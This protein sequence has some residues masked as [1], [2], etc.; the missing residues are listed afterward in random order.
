[1]ANDW[2]TSNWVAD[3]VN[4][5]ELRLR[6]ELGAM[7]KDMENQ[8]KDFSS[9]FIQLFDDHEEF[10]V[11]FNDRLEDLGRN[12]ELIQ[13]ELKSTHR[14]EG[15]SAHERQI[16]KLRQSFDV[17]R[18]DLVRL[19]A[20]IPGEIA[21]LQRPILR[22]IEQIQKDLT[23]FH[24]SINFI[25]PSSS[26]I[27]VS[28]DRFKIAGPM[29]SRRHRSINVANDTLTGKQVCLHQVDCTGQFA[30]EGFIWDV[31]AHGVI[32]LPGAV[33]LIGFGSDASGRTG[34]RVEDFI[35]HGTFSEMI[36]A[37]FKGTLPPH[38]GPTAISKVIF[39]VAVTMSQVHARHVVMNVLNG[40]SILIDE[41]YEPR[42]TNFSL[43]QFYC[44]GGDRVLDFPLF[45]APELHSG[46]GCTSAIDVFSYAVLLYTLFTQAR[47]FSGISTRN[48][49]ERMKAIH[50]GYRLMLPPEIPSA[51]RKL[52]TMCWSHNTL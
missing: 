3:L 4:Q 15:L 8:D 37:R 11:D 23:P 17:L 9:R 52:I 6:S 48:D 44:H 7:R 29:H 10:K 32:D 14:D 1:L 38:F 2:P 16:E 35:P 51:F 33:K 40:D 46:D 20:S 50:N 26:S 36:D 41:N 21:E 27:I 39:G 45:R 43:T 42:L 28:L 30:L 5:S 49:T 25:R 12:V 34:F 47:A 22:E 24:S 13:S 18:N 31:I 19:R